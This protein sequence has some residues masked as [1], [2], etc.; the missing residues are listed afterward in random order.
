M[1]C[2]TE[3]DCW[4]LAGLMLQ[5][6]EKVFKL[7][8]GDHFTDL[9][10]HIREGNEAAIDEGQ[11]VI[12]LYDEVADYEEKYGHVASLKKQLPRLKGMATRVK[13][14]IQKQIRQQ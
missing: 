6:I 12:E 8:A 5:D 1:A 13:S 3:E 10:M 2:E 7:Y 14:Y 11:E 4:E 9:L